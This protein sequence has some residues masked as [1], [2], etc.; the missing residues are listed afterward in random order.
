[1][2]WQRTSERGSLVTE[3]QLPLSLLPPAPYK[4]APPGE[5]LTLGACLLARGGIRKRRQESGRA[6]PPS[7]PPRRTPPAPCA[8]AQPR[9]GAAMGL[10]I[11][12]L[13]SRLFGKKQMRILMGKGRQRAAAA[14]RL[15][16]PG[17]LPPQPL[18]LT[19]PRPTRGPPAPSQTCPTGGG[20]GEAG[21]RGPGAQDEGGACPVPGR[22]G[23]NTSLSPF[24][25]ACGVVAK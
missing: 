19:R 20:G 2:T 24:L 8:A 5:R 11:S 7:L 18:R 3:Q 23:R 15:R 22:G 17:A 25:R 9:A 12:S 16:P 6:P 10:T 4:S 13:F 1:M 14:A 21:G